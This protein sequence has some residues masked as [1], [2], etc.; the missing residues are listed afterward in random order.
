MHFD[1]FE[2]GDF[3]YG[4]VFFFQILALKYPNKASFVLHDTLHLINSKVL[5]SNMT[6]VF[7][8]FVLILSKKS[9]LEINLKSFFVATTLKFQTFLGGD[10]KYDNSFLKLSLN[11]TQI[12][13]FSAK[14]RKFLFML[15]HLHFEKFKAFD[16]KYHHRFYSNFYLKKPQIRHF[17]SQRIL[18]YF[19]ARLIN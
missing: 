11:N 7:S 4:N 6:V 16:F 5:I 8:N 13:F 14:Y 1:K 3:K 10:F 17:Q 18:F 19:A 2:G 12:K 9:F 15:E